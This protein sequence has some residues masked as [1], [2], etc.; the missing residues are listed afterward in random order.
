MAKVSQEKPMGLS[1]GNRQQQ[2]QDDD[3]V[4][5]IAVPE[6]DRDGTPCCEKHYCQMIANGGDPKA[7]TTY[8]RC[9]VPGCGETA[10]RLRGVVPNEPAW[11][12]MR[13]CPGVAL[14]VD[15]SRSNYAQIC[16][17]CPKC[18][19]TSYLTRPSFTAPPTPLKSREDD[20]SAR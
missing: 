18:K 17:Q 14:E 10:K 3:A 13:T 8:Y 5:A 1:V 2:Q 20:F 4:E 9:R 11:C 15:E 19:S 16:M 6:R 12:G 7:G